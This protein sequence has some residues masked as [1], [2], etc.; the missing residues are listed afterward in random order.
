MIKFLLL[1]AT[2][3]GFCCAAG[4]SVENIGLSERTSE[5]K[6]KDTELDAI[7]RHLNFMSNVTY[8]NL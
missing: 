1:E 5:E 6:R 4:Y 2:A 7:N 8:H 3:I